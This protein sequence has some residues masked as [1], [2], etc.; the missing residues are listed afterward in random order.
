MS[1]KGQ[2]PPS[3]SYLEVNNNTS[4]P[5]IIRLACT[6]G[7]RASLHKRGD[8]AGL[9]L[10]TAMLCQDRHT[11]IPATA[12]YT[13]RNWAHNLHTGNPVKVCAGVMKLDESEYTPSNLPDPRACMPTGGVG[14]TVPTKAQL[15]FSQPPLGNISAIL[16]KTGTHPFGN[17]TP[18]MG[19]SF[20]A[21]QGSGQTA[22]ATIKGDTP[23]AFPHRGPDPQPARPPIQDAHNGVVTI[24]KTGT[25]SCCSTSTWP[26]PT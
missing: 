21:V 22:L 2:N 13:P 5:R 14:N 24:T 7:Y 9:P 16:D 12:M 10:S 8:A 15:S 20:A 19:Q 11:R 26:G 1:G 6:S 17:Q 3:A 25:G 4:E 18:P 23:A